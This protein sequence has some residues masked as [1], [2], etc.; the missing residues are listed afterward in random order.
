MFMKELEEKWEMIC[1][2]CGKLVYVTAKCRKTAMEKAKLQ[3]ER[4]PN[5]VHGALFTWAFQTG[6]NNS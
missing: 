6:E 1:E 5:C 4:E 3:H 2:M